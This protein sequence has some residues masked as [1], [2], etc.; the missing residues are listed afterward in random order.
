M[1]TI[2]LFVS[3]SIIVVLS[4][5]ILLQRKRIKQLQNITETDPF[6]AL[7]NYQGICKQIQKIIQRKS[8]F[9]LAIIDIDNFRNF[10]KHSYKLGDDVLKEFCL[11]LRDFLPDNVLL[12]RFRM[13]D[14]FV[15]V[16]EK[17]DLSKT[18]EIIS[19][20][21]LQFAKYRFQ[22]LQDF[23][24]TSVTFSEGVAQKKQETIILEELFAE[25]EKSLKLQKQF[26]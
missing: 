26:A 10:N 17:T 21:K 22:C 3:A 18:L 8:L 14:E 24:E 6:T 15:L 12:G 13:G 4:A 7:L 5:I 23:P 11:K 9:S 1:K 20:I 2:A 25:A 16:F 19:G